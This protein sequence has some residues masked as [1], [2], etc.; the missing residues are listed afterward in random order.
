[1]R[2]Y[3]LFLPAVAL[4]AQAAGAE[5]SWVRPIKKTSSFEGFKNSANG[6]VNNVLPW[7]WFAG[8]DENP[9]LPGYIKRND[10]L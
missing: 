5:A 10:Q 8:K 3:L 7:N 6:F 4:L 9:R 1:M 2:K